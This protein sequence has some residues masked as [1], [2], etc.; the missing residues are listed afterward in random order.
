MKWAQS[1]TV[2]LANSLPIEAQIK[3]LNGLIQIVNIRKRQC[4]CQKFY[5]F[6]FPCSHAAS[7][8]FAL[9]QSLFE[10]VPKKYLV[11]NY[12]T[13]YSKPLHLLDLTE[14]QLE[15]EPLAPPVQI[16]TGQK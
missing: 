16:S 13:T 15:S 1:N 2:Q 4:T 11:T 6:D 9:W 3:Q 14:L 8:I 7:A 10:H 5:D 12:L